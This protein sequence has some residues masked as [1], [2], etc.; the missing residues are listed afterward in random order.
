MPT[1]RKKAK[2]NIPTAFRLKNGKIITVYTD[3]TTIIGN[4]DYDSLMREYGSFITPRI[5]S[6]KNPNGCFSINGSSSYVNDQIKE[7]GND[8]IDNAA[9]IN[10]D[11]IEQ[12]TRGRKRKSND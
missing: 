5:I 9:P 6:E 3:S 1:I 12:K 11:E 4:D 10:T 8:Y 2:T 7:I